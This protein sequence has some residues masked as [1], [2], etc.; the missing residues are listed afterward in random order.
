MGLLTAAVFSSWRYAQQRKDPNGQLP[1]RG[2]PDAIVL[3][4]LSI[5]IL[6]RLLDRLVVEQSV[7]GIPQ[8]IAKQEARVSRPPEV[9]PPLLNVSIFAVRCTFDIYFT[10]NCTPHGRV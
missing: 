5:L 3:I 2:L 10:E 7:S 4:L 1:H 6:R 9:P 8:A